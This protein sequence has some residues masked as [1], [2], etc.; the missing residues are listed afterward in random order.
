M[1]KGRIKAH[2][3]DYIY[4]EIGGE[5]QINKYIRNGDDYQIVKFSSIKADFE[6]EDESAQGDIV[7]EN[8][9]AIIINSKVRRSA[10]GTKTRCTL[11]IF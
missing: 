6:F 3:H 2:L 5:I 7:S 10:D 8:H 11:D 4:L 1:K 9:S